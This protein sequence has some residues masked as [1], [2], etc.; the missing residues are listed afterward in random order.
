MSTRGGT[1]AYTC[2]EIS[3][4]KLL[5]IHCNMTLS[6]WYQTS[7]YAMSTIFVDN[8]DVEMAA[9]SSMRETLYGG[10]SLTY[11]FTYT[12]GSTNSFTVT[13]S[14]STGHHVKFSFN[15]TFIY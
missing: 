4:Y 15:L 11:A 13:C 9:G 7:T 14:S 5:R 6:V 8:D 12:A 1:Q 3:S 10:A 2:S